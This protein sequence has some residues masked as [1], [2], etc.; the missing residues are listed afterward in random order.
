VADPSDAEIPGRA[1]PRPEATTAKRPAAKRRAAVTATRATGPLSVRHRSLF[2]PQGRESEGVAFLIG[3]E[4]GS[5][6]RSGE[7]KLGHSSGGF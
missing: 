6:D 3:R 7:R 5:L 1:A 2:G 4:D